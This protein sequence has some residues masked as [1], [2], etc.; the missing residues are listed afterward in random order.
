MAKKRTPVSP[1]QDRIVTDV[2]ERTKS[3]IPEFDQIA[4]EIEASQDNRTAWNL[5]Q[6][7]YYRMRMR[8]RKD[9]SSPFPGCSNLRLPT[10][11]KYIRKAKASVI[12][13]IAGQR[14]RATVIPGPFTNQD[15]AFKLE[16]YLDYLFD[17]KIRALK[18]LT[19]L[20][21]KTYEKG[22]GFMEV[23][24]RMDEELHRVKVN[25]D[26]IPVEL[27]QRIFQ[28]DS[29]DELLP[30]LMQIFDID[31][32]D[33][34][35]A[36]NEDELRLAL[37][38][39]RAG[40]SEVTITL[41]DE[42]YNNVDWEYH[43]AEFV[44]APADAR[45]DPQNARWLAI[46][47]YENVEVVKQ[48]A[49]DGIYDAVSVG[50]IEA[51]T[52]FDVADNSPTMDLFRQSTMTKDLRE[53][54]MR[55]SGSGNIKLWRVYKWHDLNGDDIEERSVFILA[56]EFKKV[57]ARAPYPHDMRK[58]PLV[59]FDSE[60]T[61]DRWLST[62][63]YPEIIEDI[64]KEIDTQHNQKIDQQTIRN[65]PMFTFR[66]G[67]IN[68]KLVRF[69][70]AQAIPVPGTTPLGDAVQILRNESTN[71]EFSYRDEELLLKSEVQ[72]L[73][74]HS[75]F[76]T[77]S[78]INRR[79]PRTATEVGAAQQAANVVFTMESMLWADN[80]SELFQMTLALLQ[81]Y[82][83]NEVYFSVV[84][85]GASIRLTRDEIQGEYITRIRGNDLTV[86]PIQRLNMALQEAQFLMQP[87]LI[88]SGIV[89]PQNIFNIAKGYLQKAGELSWQAKISSPA[90]PQGPPPPITQIPPKW[91]ELTDAEKMQ[92]L[93]SGGVQPDVEGRAI[94]KQ[95]EFVNAEA[96][97]EDKSAA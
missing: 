63:G 81:Q 95:E 22:F 83:P 2:I 45:I 55:A 10:A 51:M 73:L 87:I 34:V 31:Q 97:N 79:E 56:P 7:L 78:L 17:N 58:W 89:T 86:N 6:D 23:L 12:S 94:R 72:E 30:Y 75:D 50:D 92:I 67:I 91:E 52:K 90:P 8:I 80:M 14:P 21:D 20:A 69:M 41:R 5:K 93:S 37:Q 46:E 15:A 42:V 62:R 57:L 48:K 33:S 19:I 71:V 32:G 3:D 44:Y 26:E 49:R 61:D 25:L 11:E 28:T 65:A 74:G 60:L 24:W 38:A 27:A 16:Y 13:F 68:P 77:Q 66:S 76:S 9:K 4:K 39:F 47:V 53:G 54:I 1:P 35:R 70:P 18:K 88:Q 82:L 36:Q 64:I 43:D 84:G 59:R 40:K 29:D 96:G 85:E